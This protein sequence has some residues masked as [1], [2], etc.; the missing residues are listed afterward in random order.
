MAYSPSQV[1]EDGVLVRR[2][3]ETNRWSVDADG[4]PIDPDDT[5]SFRDTVESKPVARKRTT[6]K[7]S[8]K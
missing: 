4:N 7:T 5:E 3:I 1:W 6:R 2:N 8:K